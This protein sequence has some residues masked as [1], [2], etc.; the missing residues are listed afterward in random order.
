MVLLTGFYLDPDPARRAELVECL[1]RNVANDALDAVHVLLEDAADPAA[2]AAA[3]DPFRAAKV[4]LVAHGRRSTYR[5]LFDYAN[6][7]PAGT[8]VAVA[9]ADIYFDESLRRAASE[10]LTQRLLCLSRWDVLADGRLALFEHPA[11]Q[12]AWI[13]RVPLPAFPCEFP[14]GV[15]GCD[16]R[17]AWEASNAGLTVS[18]PARS[19]RACHLH[20]SG[21]RR[22]TE[23]QR[24]AGPVLTVPASRLGR[25]GAAPASDHAHAAF[26]EDMGYSI[27]RLAPGVSSHNNLAR[28]IATVPTPLAGLEF[29]QVVAYRASPVELEFLSPGKVYVLVGDDWYGYHPA[30]EW[31]ELEGYRE[32]LPALLTQCGAGFEVWSLVGKAGERFVL[33]T[34]VMLA[35]RELTRR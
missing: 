11:S 10:D 6:R 34:Q 28:P 17:L 3:Y 24:V 1:S 15:P 9:N 2:L 22:Y 18:N 32:P 30:T 27:G 26:S 16:N 7:L 14:L 8:V 12:D 23:R 5:D 20:H 33:P 31:L 35:A 21:V 29:T 25:R 19:V 13:F 4:H